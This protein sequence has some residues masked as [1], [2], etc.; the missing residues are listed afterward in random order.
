M[1]ILGNDRQKI[2]VDS[3]KQMVE[4]GHMSCLAKPSASTVEIEPIRY[5]PPSPYALDVEVFSLSEF[6]QRVVADQLRKA[7]RIGFHLLLLV[8]RGGC[9]HMVDFESFRCRPG[10][11]LVLRPGQVQRYEARHTNW[12]GWLV[13]FR[14]EFLATSV[15]KKKV[16]DLEVLSR[17][18][19]LPVHIVLKRQDRDAVA[20]AFSRMSMDCRLGTD[21]EL[22][23]SLLRSQL[24]AVLTRLQLAQRQRE[25]T[26]DATASHMSHFKRFRSAV[27]Q[28]F[29]RWHR[30]GEHAASLGC[31]EKTLTRAAWAVV[32]KS[33]KKMLSQRIALEAKRLLVHTSSP[34]SAIANELGFDEATNFVKFFKREV[35]A[36]PGD[37]RRKYASPI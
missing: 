6:H 22:R 34:I 11:L 4:S 31:S 5:V 1:Y 17:L 2:E 18:E 32:N 21:V 15:G 16:T 27:E 20:E 9:T 12:H 19:E 13:L 14:P 24:L 26:L 30:V 25:D 23:H 7:Q 10:S 3:R 35:S 8:T 37:F 28:E 29:P 36:L 33:A